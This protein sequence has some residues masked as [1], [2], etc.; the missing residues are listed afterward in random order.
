M[1]CTVCGT[2]MNEE[3][4]FCPACGHLVRSE[5]SSLSFPGND[6]C[7]KHISTTRNKK[8]DDD[9]SSSVP[10]RKLK[11]YIGGVAMGANLRGNRAGIFIFGLVFFAACA[12]GFILSSRDNAPTTAEKPQPVQKHT[13]ERD[14]RSAPQST[15]RKTDKQ[16]DKKTDKPAPVNKKTSLKDMQKAIA[17][18]G[19]KGTVLATTALGNPPS[20]LSLSLVEDEGRYRKIVFYDPNDSRTAYIDYY[21]SQLSGIGSREG[22][23]SVM[24]HLHILNA[25]HEDDAEAGVWRGDEHIIPIMA[26]YTYSRGVVSPGMIKTANGMMNPDH[27]TEYLYEKRHVDYVNTLLSQMPALDRDMGIR[28][29]PL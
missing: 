10:L 14:T 3:D 18:K 7:V 2:Q 16:T 22:E 19:Y 9:I 29:I 11:D 6:E 25:S 8:M 13:E 23:G 5:I 24:F 20:A 15:D 27:Y 17:A 28:D 12:G 26:E 1:F 4:N 21:P